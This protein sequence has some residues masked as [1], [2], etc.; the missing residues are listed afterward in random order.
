MS[1]ERKMSS[2]T[3]DASDEHAPRVLTAVQGLFSCQD[4]LTPVV[5]VDPSVSKEPM[6]NAFRVGGFVLMLL[7]ENIRDPDAAVRH[8]GDG[9]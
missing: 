6:T 4:P 5:G 9:L 2:A 7:V 8:P 3:S 1:G